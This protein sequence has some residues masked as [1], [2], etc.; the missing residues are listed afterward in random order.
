[1]KVLFTRPSCLIKVLLS[2]K[3]GGKHKL[4]PQ[5]NQMNLRSTKNTIIFQEDDWP[6]A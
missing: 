4:K 1:M 6:N 2:V 5:L 3:Y